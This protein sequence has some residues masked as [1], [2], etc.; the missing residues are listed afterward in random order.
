MPHASLRLILFLSLF[1]SVTT[2]LQSEER[3]FVSNPRMTLGTGANLSAAV[4]IADL[5]GDGQPDVV[6]A[7][8]RHWPQQNYIFFNQ[9][10]A[11]FNLQRPLGKD[12]STS[13]ATEPADLDGDGDLD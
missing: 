1:I 10:R 6:V 12:L 3:R 4:R 8:G 5:N 9:G 2:D 7:N 11:K 13:Y